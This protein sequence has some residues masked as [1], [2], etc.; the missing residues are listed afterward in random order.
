[1]GRRQAY[2]FSR[3][4]EEG[5]VSMDIDSKQAWK[6]ALDIDVIDKN[7]LYK[8]SELENEDIV[9][10]EHG[11]V[12][13]V[14]EVRTSIEQFKEEDRQFYTTTE[15]HASIDARVMLE[16]AIES[17][18]ENQMYEDWDEKILEDITDKDIEK[19]QVIL[20][21]IFSRSEVQNTAYY[22]NEKIDIY[23]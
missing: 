19:I 1:M 11:E 17:E 12:Y 4:V 13:S 8:L 22:E 15:Y 21:D 7:E 2:I 5:G 6:H 9:I 3:E 23:N 16:S 10:D 18:Y 20:D 14:E